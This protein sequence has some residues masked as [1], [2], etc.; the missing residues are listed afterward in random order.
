MSQVTK[1]RW[2]EMRT[3]ET[4]T[5]EEFL[6]EYFDW[7]G[8]YRYNSASI[9][10]CVIDERFEGKSFV[11]RDTMVE[12][13]LKELPPETQADIINLITLAPSEKDDDLTYLEFIDPSPSRL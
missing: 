5:V 1:H 12:R 3:D 8:A 13:Y 9:R 2:E 10:V 4:R 6:G 7:V 11:R